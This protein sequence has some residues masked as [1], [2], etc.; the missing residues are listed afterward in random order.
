VELAEGGTLF[1]DELGDLPI[2][3]QGK[4]LRFLQERTFERVGGRQTLRANVRIV[5]ATHR[6]LER[7]VGSGKFREDLYYRVRVVEIDLPPLRD[8]GP[9]EVERLARHFADV[10][11]GRYNRPTPRFEQEALRAMRSHSWPGN[12]RELEHW[13]ESAIAL[14]PDGRITA[15]H[16]PARRREYT[17]VAPSAS[18]GVSPGSE[19]SPS[20]SA[21]MN[22]WFEERAGGGGAGE[23]SD[24]NLAAALHGDQGSVSIPLGLSLEEAARRYVEATVTACDGNKT[25]AARRLDVGRNTITRSLQKRGRA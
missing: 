3:I 7:A 20:L 19:S 21:A 8:R 12:V 17:N 9:E 18:S 4:L 14:A 25:E 10:Y 1:L 2:D 13:I 23:K 5:C 6:D 11:A 15:S 22:D 24:P 16:L